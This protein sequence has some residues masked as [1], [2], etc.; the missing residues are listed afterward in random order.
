MDSIW[1]FA[2]EE[3]RKKKGKGRCL[4]LFWLQRVT[5]AS[6]QIIPCFSPPLLLQAGS[7][8]EEIR[9]IYEK[10]KKK[11]QWIYSMTDHIKTNISFF[12]SIPHGRLLHAGKETGNDASRVTLQVLGRAK[13]R[14]SPLSTQGRAFCARL[15]TS[16]EL[17]ENLPA[18]NHVTSCRIRSSVQPLLWHAVSEG[19]EVVTWASVLSLPLFLSLLL[20]FV[21]ESFTFTLQWYSLFKFLFL[22]D[23][24][25]LYV[26][27]MKLWQ[28]A[29]V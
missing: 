17:L 18:A 27:D 20:D 2:S 25:I 3:K 29:G 22:K 7:I 10:K 6:T 12:P 11:K 19:V 4:E 28:V 26:Q 13:D 1:L 21:F 14:V 23:A 8:Q 24:A 5:F 15:D 9:A 16:P